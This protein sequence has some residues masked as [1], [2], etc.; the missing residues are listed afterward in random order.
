MLWQRVLAL[1]FRRAALWLP[2]GLALGIWL[3]F[4][5]PDEPPGWT[6][7]L[8]ALPAASIVMPAV[9]RA[10]LGRVVVLAALSL[11]LGFALALG[12]AMRAEGPRL[13]APVTGTVEGRVIAVDRAGSGAPRVLL[14]RASLFGYRASRVPRRARI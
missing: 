8:P 1:E 4:A 11:S 12:A 2:V 6:L 5:L 9:R 3:Y 13:Q 7:W 14:E 10:M